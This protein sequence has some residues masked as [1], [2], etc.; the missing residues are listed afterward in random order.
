M[1][2][3]SRINRY[4]PKDTEHRIDTPSERHKRIFKLLDPF[5]SF[6]FLTTSAINY[7]E[8]VNSI[9]NSKQLGYLYQAPN[10]YL[11]R[12]PEQQ[13]SHAYHYRDAVYSIGH[14]GKRCLADDGYVWRDAKHRSREFAHEFNIDMGFYLPMM[15]AVK[16][17]PALTLI[18]TREFFNHP[19]TPRAT[20]ESEHPFQ[21]VI[22][23]ERVILDGRPVVLKYNEA[24]ICVPGI[25]HERNTKGVRV[26]D[27]DRSSVGKHVRHAIAAHEQRIYEKHY[28][29]DNF[30]LPFIFTNEAQMHLTLQYILELRPSG[31]ASII[32]KTIPDLAYETAFPK[33]SSD[34][35]LSPWLRAGHPPFTFSEHDFFPRRGM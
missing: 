33:P 1:E 28:G 13:K 14:A 8:P 24:S 21:V 32:C 12:D 22:G 3:R 10:F 11:D 18:D 30:I 19:N 26:K 27:Q 34:Y 15:V 2:R 25:Q 17:N 31:A 35:F 23:D 20:R 4:P 29:F 16:E 5:F 7:L 6:K 9:Y